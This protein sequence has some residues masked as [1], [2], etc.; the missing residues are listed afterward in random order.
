M[1]KELIRVT[2]SGRRD[3]IENDIDYIKKQANKI[4]KIFQVEYLMAGFIDRKKPF[5]FEVVKEKSSVR[6]F[7]STYLSND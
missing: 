2:D 6:C 5:Q 1:D 7:I 4:F 3:R